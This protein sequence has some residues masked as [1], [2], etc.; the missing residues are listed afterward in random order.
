MQRPTSK[1]NVFI[2]RL[3]MKNLLFL[4]TETGGR[5][6]QTNGIIQVAGFLDSVS[7]INDIELLEKFNFTSNVYPDQVLENDAL[8]INGHTREAIADYEKPELV[9]SNFHDTVNKHGLSFVNKHTLVAYNAKF[10][11][12]F[13]EVWYEK[14]NVVDKKGRPQKFF[15]IFGGQVIDVQSLVVD[16]IVWNNL[17]LKDCKLPTI[18]KYLK[19]DHKAHDAFSDIEVT[20]EI[21]YRIKRMQIKNL[22]FSSMTIPFEIKKEELEVVELE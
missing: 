20:R 10:D 9:A 3:R 19:I 18:A 12:E 15:Y 7:G 16:L 5:N 1:R 6:P 21:F 14:A 2:E 17:K 11:K 13:L 22:P 4:D 8:E